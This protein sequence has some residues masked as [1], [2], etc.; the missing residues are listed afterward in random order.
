MIYDDISSGDLA[1]KPQTVNGF[2]L[3]TFLLMLPSGAFFSLSVK[4]AVL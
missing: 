3:K 2:E 1:E 4:I